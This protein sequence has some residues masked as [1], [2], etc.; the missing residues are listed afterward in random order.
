MEPVSEDSS[1]EECYEEE[2]E[3][4]EKFKKAKGFRLQ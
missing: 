2:E 1:I 4:E 3:E